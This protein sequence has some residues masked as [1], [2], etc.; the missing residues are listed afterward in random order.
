MINLGSLKEEELDAL[1]EL[2]NIGV[3]HAATSLSTMLGKMVEM[4]VPK[5]IVAKFSEIH[6][7]FKDEVITGIVTG[8]EDIENGRTGYLYISFPDA[9]KLSSI[10]ID[11]SS[12]ADSTIMEIGNILSSSFCNAIADMLGIV[13][14]PTPPSFAEDTSI[15][16]VETIVA[17]IAEK[18][19][20]IIIFETELRESDYAIEILMTLV[21]DE[22]FLGYIIKM[23]GMLG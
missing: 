21:P 1:K 15:A 10:F 19:D 23:L 16:I 11:D 20:W 4:T 22:K 12:L 7:Y 6:N 9:K 2:G 5:V 14:V 13:L 17:Q 3:A 18:G 8:L